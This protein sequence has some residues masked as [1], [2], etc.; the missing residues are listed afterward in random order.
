MNR[1]ILASAVWRKALAIVLRHPVATLVPALMGHFELVFLTAALAVV[2]EEAITD[3]GTLGGLALTGSET[4]G[5][6]IGGSIAT[7]LILP[8]ASFATALAY[9]HLRRS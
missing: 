5:A 4:W 9:G 2:V 6:W 3:A 7:V 1:R 8:A